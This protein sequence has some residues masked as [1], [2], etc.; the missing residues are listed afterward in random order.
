M[1]VADEVCHLVLSEDLPDRAGHGGGL[2]ENPF[3]GA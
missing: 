3:R 2:V 1:S